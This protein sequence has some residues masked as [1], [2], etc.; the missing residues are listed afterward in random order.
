MLRDIE[1]GWI[2]FSEIERKL[3][4]DITF[5]GEFVHDPFTGKISGIGHVITPADNSADCLARTGGTII[6]LESSGGHVSGGGKDTTPADARPA[7]NGNQKTW[8]YIAADLGKQNG[9][10]A[11]ISMNGETTVSA[12][13]FKAISD[14]KINVE[15]VY[16]SAK[17][18]L[19]V[20]E[21]ITAVS[22]VDFSLL[23]GFADVGSLRGVSGGKYRISAGRAERIIR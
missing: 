5:S 11:T 3:A 1:N 7:I 9:S 23:P 18:W 4:N 2:D 20:G 12:E 17:S 15:F 14:R 21:K 10:S 6:N 13:V 16:D 8:A 19:V 22:T